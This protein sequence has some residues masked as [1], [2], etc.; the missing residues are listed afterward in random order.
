MSMRK[1]SKK[2]KTSD[3]P[4]PETPTRASRRRSV[5]P[6]G[7]S[8]EH[9]D[10]LVLSS[11][12]Q[13][14]ENA[15]SNRIDSEEEELVLKQPAAFSEEEDSEA[16]ESEEKDAQSEDSMESGESSEEDSSSEIAENPRGKKAAA[17]PKAA[18][19]RKAPVKKD[20]KKEAPGKSK[21][22]TK[23]AKSALLR[24]IKEKNEPMNLVELGLIFQ[25]G[26]AAM[27]AAV[28]KKTLAE[29]VSENL[30]EEKKPG[31]TTIYL[32]VH[33][34]EDNNVDTAELDEEIAQLKEE[35][36]GRQERV[37]ELRQR[38]KELTADPTDEELVQALQEISADLSE[39]EA[40]VCNFEK[41]HKL[42]D[43]KEKAKI[44]KEIL[45]SQKLKKSIRRHF[46]NIVGDICEGAGKKPAELM[47]EMGIE[48]PKN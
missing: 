36:A 3:K 16:K 11:D 40:R 26:E 32:P 38:K 15:P 31:V 45:N 28:L 47:E 21:V 17:S 9:L 37:A 27:T 1:A 20:A 39:K 7:G 22:M 24:Y 44:E 10:E 4:L 35:V 41:N 14:N 34:K 5:S 29:L 25:T 12:C 46:K 8:E 30:V 43:P 48:E 33:T 23:T 42:V 18:A 13:N 6:E 19:K 2:P